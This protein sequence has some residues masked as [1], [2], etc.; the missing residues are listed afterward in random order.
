MSKKYLIIGGLLL[1][2]ILILVA[3][4]LLGGGSEDP[5]ARRRSNQQV[6]LVWWKTFEDQQNFQELISAYTQ[7]N[8]GISVRFVKKDPATYEQELLEALATG[9]G[10]DIISI[11]NDWLPRHHEKLSP[12][13]QSMMSEKVYRET[14]LEVASDD[15]IREGR[16]YAIPLSVD[17]LALYYNKDLLHSAGISQPPKTWT[18]MIDAV[19]QVTQMD[20]SGEFS[21]SALAMGASSNV[22]RAVDIVSLLM[23][24][25]GTKIYDQSTGRYTLDSMY[26]EGGQSF[27]PGTEA[28]KY[29]TQFTNPGKTVYT[30]N[31]RSNN[32]ID[33]FS[34]NKL[35]MMLSYYYMQE[36]I[37]SKAPNLNWG[38]AFV[39][40]PD[41][42]G[43]KVNFANYWGEAVAKSSKNQDVAWDFL[44]FLGQKESLAAY[45]AKHKLPASRKDMVT[46][47]FSDL[48]VGIFAE[49]ALTAKSAY[50]TDANVF[51][52]IFL[53][54]IDDVVLRNAS[55]EEAIRS[56]TQ[57]LQMVK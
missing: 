9:T 19:K 40:Q 37:L 24:Q 6:E 3:L 29:Y 57:Q 41:L 10:P 33:A 45:Y 35:A 22:N 38:V 2:F 14:F 18:E 56:A 50:K 39:P 28:L 42:A 5:E 49:S 27:S 12:M 1:F 55:P 34:Q 25:N 51:E 15:F 21:P 32:S 47:Q 26:R 20:K 11:H 52:G 30:W 54:M 31:S 13:P 4:L 44:R 7:T 36:R 17:V 23:L 16:I 43:I 53:K 48:Q 46:E 8:K